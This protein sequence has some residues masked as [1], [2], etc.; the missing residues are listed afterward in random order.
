MRKYIKKF[1][2][3]FL[4][5][6]FSIVVSACSNNDNSWALKTEN[7][8]VSNELYV[9]FLFEAYNNAIMELSEGAE[10]IDDLENQQIE[11]KS[12]SNWIKDTAINNTKKM[13]A[14][15]KFFD[16]KGLKL[17]EE[18][19]KQIDEE[20]KSSFET[21]KET[22]EKYGINLD[23]LKRAYSLQNVKSQKLF[24]SIYQK[25]GSEVVSDNDIINFYKNNYV[26]ISTIMKNTQ[27]NAEADDENKINENA[28]LIEK[29]EQQ[30]KDYV[31]AI[32]NGQKSLTDVANDFKQSENLN[33][34]PVHTESLNP[35]EIGFSE[36]IVNKILQLEVN[37]ADYFSVANTFLLI[38]KNNINSSLPNLS[39]EEEKNKLLIEMKSLD[40][41][42]LLKS[43][44]NEMQIKVN[45][46]SIK[47][48]QPSKLFKEN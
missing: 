47:K 31:T 33:E 19:I 8:A 14:V 45:E 21:S 23:A 3:I 5:G 16:E 11:G 48:Y 12:A 37:K 13:L 36:E 7:N 2:A 4:M 10:S 28:A 24:N 39:N 20:S 38:Y 32:N 6:I 15:E 41:D 44:A 42:N 43:I 30:F 26:N 34:D 29:T 35:K 27:S 25:D 22:F 18:E 1:F 17:S 40:F 46:N 9:Y